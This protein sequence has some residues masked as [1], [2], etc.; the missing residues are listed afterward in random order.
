MRIEL[1]PDERLENIG[2]GLKVIQNPAWFCYGTDAVML[3]QFAAVKPGEKLVDFCTGTGIIP[4][5]LF[6][7]SKCMDMAGLE[8]Q[9]AVADMARRSVKWNGLESNIKIIDGDLRESK[10]YFAAESVDVITCNPPYM[11]NNTGKQ[12]TNDSKTI[13]RHEV[14][15]TIKDVIQNAGYLLRTG[16]RFYLVHRPERLADIFYWMRYYR[17]EPKRL[18]FVHSKLEQPPSLVLLEGQKGRKSGLIVHGPILAK[19]VGA[20]GAK[21]IGGEN[22]DG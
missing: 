1:K 4:L 2:N 6:S 13:A 19:S 18:Q 5:L 9:V 16:G 12:N 7:R 14:C 22:D 15:C 10:R 20:A 8:I 3:A 11:C 17:L 21:E